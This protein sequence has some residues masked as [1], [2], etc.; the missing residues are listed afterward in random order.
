MAPG[1]V[2]IGLRSSGLHS[3][4][5]S[6]ARRA[7]GDAGWP[8]VADRLLEPTRVYVG[9]A[10]C[11]VGGR[12]AVARDGPHLR[13]RPAEPAA[14]GRAGRATYW[15]RC[16]SRP[17]SSRLRTVGGRRRAGARCTPR[18]TWASA[19]ASWCRRMRST[20]PWRPWARAGH[21][22]G[23]GRPRPPGRDAGRRARGPRRRLL[24]DAV[25]DHRPNL[26]MTNVVDLLETLV[27]IDAT[28]PTIAPGAA[29]EAAMGRFVASHLRGL[30][31]SVTVDE[32]APGRSNVVGVAQGPPGMPGLLLA[33][34]LD[35]VPEPPAAS[36]AGA[37]ADRLSG[38]RGL[39]LQGVDRR[40]S[41]GRR[42]TRSTRS[43]RRG[44][45]L[46]G[47]WRRARGARSCSA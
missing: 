5:Y 1:D 6:L 14:V 15:T 29:G 27:A 36:S 40:H 22:P 39:R 8:T 16:R 10:R 23:G 28:N 9:A 44:P 42:S 19:C 47:A 25:R 41:C 7:L 12:R 24:L 21:R 20:P 30:G 18:S 31:L 37:K 33:A 38:A 32:V 4:G 17:R 3:N 2:V 46:S 13:R 45:P 34:H 43:R 11:V 35:T 26:D